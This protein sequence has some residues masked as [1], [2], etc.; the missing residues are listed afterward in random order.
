MSQEYV[1]E[2]GVPMPNN[3]TTAL[4]QALRAMEIGDSFLIINRNF[5]LAM[6]QRKI[7]IKLTQRKTD[8]GY[9]IWRTA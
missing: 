2:K 9:R 4:S 3:K 7:G 6:Y 8:G 5:N 1:I